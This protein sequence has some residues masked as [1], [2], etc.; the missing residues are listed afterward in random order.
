MES[1]DYKKLLLQGIPENLPVPRPFDQEVNHAP[2][3]KDILSKD[4]KK[5]ALRNALR[6]F[7]KKHHTVLAPEFAEELRKYGRIYMYRFRPAYNMFARP[8]HEYPH[9]SLQAAAIMLMIQNN[10][11]PAVAQH[12]HHLRR[13]RGSLPEL[14]SVPVD[15]E[16][17][18][19]DDR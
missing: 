6:Y 19:G 11:D 9:K 7:D 10:L 13:Q 5:L 4:E 8:I 2:I 1:T 15:N 3:R 14:G 16:I 12:P 18:I 17:F